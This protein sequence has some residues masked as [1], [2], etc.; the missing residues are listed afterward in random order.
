MRILLTGATGFAG[1]TLAEA[2]LS[3]PDVRL[4]GL[5]RR[6]EWPPE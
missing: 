5:S 6:G 3:K 4:C 1:S 2:L